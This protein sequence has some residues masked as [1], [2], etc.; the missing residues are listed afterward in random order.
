[1]NVNSNLYK[2]KSVVKLTAFG[3][4]FAWAFMFAT[5]ANA[6]S[7]E[8]TPSLTPTTSLQL[9]YYQPRAAAAAKA[10]A[11]KRHHHP[12]HRHPVQRRFHR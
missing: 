8:I 3:S 9:A 5:P 11:V 12:V 4:L 6:S 1:M 2:I 7:K 10:A